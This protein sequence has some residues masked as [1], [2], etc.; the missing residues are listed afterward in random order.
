MSTCALICYCIVTTK[1]ELGLTYICAVYD[2]KLAV[3]TEQ[4]PLSALQLCWT[5]HNAACVTGQQLWLK[6]ATQALQC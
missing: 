4:T 6:Q 2:K 3:D 1:L 5:L